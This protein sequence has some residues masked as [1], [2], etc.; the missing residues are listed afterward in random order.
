M[1]ACKSKEI[2]IIHGPLHHI[3]SSEFL[4]VFF[5]FYGS[6]KSASQRAMRATVRAMRVAR[7]MGA[8]FFFDWSGRSSIISQTNKFKFSYKSAPWK[9][10]YLASLA[11]TIAV[12]SNIKCGRNILDEFWYWMWAKITLFFRQNI[13][14]Y[15]WVLPWDSLTSL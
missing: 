3:T 2:P 13:L 1:G 14:R 15:G 8:I 4:P 7:V 12:G 6:A 10:P 5:F 11:R 9:F